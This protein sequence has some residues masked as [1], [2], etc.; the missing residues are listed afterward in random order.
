MHG[1]ASLLLFASGMALLTV[2]VLPAKAQSDRRYQRDVQLPPPSAAW[3]ER[4]SQVFQPS[5]LNGLQL[6]VTALLEPPLPMPEPQPQR[7]PMFSDGWTRDGFGG[8]PEEWR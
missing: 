2:S 3:R 6:D 8:R 5:G 4:N 7:R 1:R